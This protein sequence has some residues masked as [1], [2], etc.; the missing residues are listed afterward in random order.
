MVFI[1]ANDV[2][3]IKT[4]YNFRHPIYYKNFDGFV[5]TKNKKYMF[6]VRLEVQRDTAL[7]RLEIHGTQQTLLRIH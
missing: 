7:L 5:I 2:Y 6:T 3:P 4:H 1:S